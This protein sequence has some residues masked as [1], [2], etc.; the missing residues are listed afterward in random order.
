MYSIR[1]IYK[2]M[3]EAVNGICDKITFRIGHSPSTR[4]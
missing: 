1:Q 2:S 4:G 3:Y